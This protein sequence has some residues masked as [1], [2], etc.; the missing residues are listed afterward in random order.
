MPLV[1]AEKMLSLFREF[2]NDL[3]THDILVALEAEHARLVGEKIIDD[4]RATSEK[5]VL[6]AIEGIIAR[7]VLGEARTFFDTLPQTIQVFLFE[8]FFYFEDALLALGKK[9]LEFPAQFELFLHQGLI[10]HWNLRR[11]RGWF[12]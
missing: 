9:Q 2:K 4:L 11:E 3:F 10:G 1:N 5:A 8:R 12:F 7:P 6:E